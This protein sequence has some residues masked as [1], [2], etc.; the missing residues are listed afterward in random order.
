MQQQAAIWA[1]FG[2]GKWLQVC[3]TNH[4]NNFYKTVFDWKN[5]IA[6]PQCLR[7]G[8]MHLQTQAD[9][10]VEGYVFFTGYCCLCFCSMG[11]MAITADFL[12]SADSGPAEGALTLRYP[13]GSD[14]SCQNLHL[15]LLLW[16]V[17][18]QLLPHGALLHTPANQLHFISG[19]PPSGCG[20][21]SHL[22]YPVHLW[23]PV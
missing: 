21:F 20:P 11:W 6:S 14:G 9:K 18:L 22:C 10:E 13:E 2:V 5:F 17:L 16:G 15:S 1:F 23:S 7:G 3:S 19:R 12:R 8:S 4:L